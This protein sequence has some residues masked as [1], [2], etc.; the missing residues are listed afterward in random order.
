MAPAPC[1]ATFFFFFLHF[2][3]DVS[4]IRVLF[5]HT[6]VCQGCSVGNNERLCAIIV[7]AFAV[8]RRT[9][10]RVHGWNTLKTYLNVLFTCVHAVM[11]QFCSSYNM[12]KIGFHHAVC[13]RFHQGWICVWGRW[14]DAGRAGCYC[15]PFTVFLQSERLVQKL[16]FATTLI[17]KVNALKKVFLS[18]SVMIIDHMHGVKFWSLLF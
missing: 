7:Q 17:Q 9:E 10:V 11:C 4:A 2:Y 6:A 16:V 15:S 14:Y 18:V 5:H 1:P 12:I 13:S 3:W 8:R